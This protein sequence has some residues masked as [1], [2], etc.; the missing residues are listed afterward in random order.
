M[1]K[2]ITAEG[3][4]PSQNKWVVVRPLIL[5]LLFGVLYHA[6]L[7]F[8][9]YDWWTDNNYSHGFIVPLVSAY[10]I[11]ERKD[12]LT[13]L[14]PSPNLL[15]LFLFLAGI[16]V[17]I[18]GHVGAE[19]FLMRFSMLLVISG[20]VLFLL[21][22]EFLRVLLFPIGFL[23]YMIP[24]PQVIFN[25]IAFP[26]QLF[27]AQV[28]T[29]ILQSLGI[30]VLRE[31]NII[32]LAYSTLEVAEACS[33]IRS[34]VTLLTLSTVYS[35]FTQDRL[36]KHVVLIISAIP[37]AV[38][39]N[40]TRV[41][42]TGILAHYFGAG[43]AQGFY[44]TFSGWL[45]FMV[46]F[47]LLLLV[48][49]FLS[50][51]TRLIG[52]KRDLTDKTNMVEQVDISTGAVASKGRSNI[53]Q[54]LVAVVVFL[55]AIGFVHFWWSHGEAIP[56]RKKLATFPLDIGNWEG[57]EEGLPGDVL[58][59]VRV[60]D[61]MM[62]WYVSKTSEKP[63]VPINFYVGYYETQRKGATYHSPRNC[64]PGG[65]WQIVDSERVSIDVQ[66]N[67]TIIINKI[68]IQKGLDKQ[69]LLYWYQDRGRIIAS[70]YW[71]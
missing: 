65:G 7:S 22:T 41:T 36:W 53:S 58:E 57:R 71:A 61:Y 55:A 27:A 42:G 45:V 30:P 50:R 35:Y 29:G 4:S 2:I 69:L 49:I 13:K 5:C 15:G 9:V 10:L 24:L 6:I 31:G 60:D 1:D 12:I 44:H 62:R 8:L 16:G 52:N 64:L 21:G 51:I 34:L 43:V 39:A 26:L 37:I 19:L 11:W 40:S 23:I 59:K 54:F 14:K 32:Q 56:L 33:G 48:G 38:I 67:K 17:L 68:L 47:G 18:L 28:A 66:E 46:A 3:M 25:A 63:S 20:L 70:E